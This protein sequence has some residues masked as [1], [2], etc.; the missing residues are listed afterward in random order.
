VALLFEEIA[1]HTLMLRTEERTCSTVYLIEENGKRLIVDSGDGGVKI[2]F[3]PDVC[4]LTHGHYDHSGGVRE[5][6]GKVLLHKEEF[7]FRGPFIHIPKNASPL[8]MAPLKFGSH[9]LEFFHTPGHTKGSICVLD[10]KT[11]L[12]FSG[13]TKFADGGYGR[14]DLG[15]S[16]REMEGSLKLIGKIPYKLLC[17]GHGPVEEK[18]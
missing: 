7:L 16:E 13:D 2:D 18:E 8:T 12:L 4:I 6:W 1:R 14:T 17:P 3:V 11:G 15:G 10:K 9:L 5:S